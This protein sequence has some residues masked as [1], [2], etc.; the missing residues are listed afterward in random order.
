METPP[1][2]EIDNLN[3]AYNQ[4][5][6]LQDINLS[7]R[8][9]ELLCMV[10]PNGGGKTTLLKLILG[11]LKPDNGNIR[12]FNKSP[13]QAALLIGYVPQQILFDPA[14]PVNV[15][16]VVL[17]G[18]IHNTKTGRYSKAHRQKGFSALEE[19]DLASAWRRPFVSLSGG[20]RQRVLIARGLVAEPGLLLLDEP[21]S[22]VDEI[23][24]QKLSLLLKELNKRMTIIYVSH[25][26]GLVSTMVTTVACINRTLSIHPTNE[27]TGETI[28]SI[29]RDNMALVRHDHRCS[30]KGHTH[31]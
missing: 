11:L 24:A 20:Q 10:G 9:N 25:D 15:L 14:F 16:D 1:V 12:V 3:F 7:V 29:Y 18:F 13:R 17:M 6:V 5:T 23:S 22:G 21:V 4:S 30:E 8:R 28:N 19:V 2:I 27:L 26:L 31:D